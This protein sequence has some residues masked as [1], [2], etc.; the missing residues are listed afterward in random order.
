MPRRSPRAGARP[1]GQPTLREATGTL[2]TRETA[3]SP[4]GP[5]A[6]VAA[7]PLA[8][9]RGTVV[10]VGGPLALA[11]ASAIAPVAAVRRW[12]G[13][14]PA[15]RWRSLGWAATAAG[16]AT[17]WVYGLA[18]RPWLQHWGSTRAERTATYP[19]DEPGGAPWFRTTRAVTVAAPAATVWAWL[20]QIGQD[21]GGFYSYDWL[22]N[23]AGCRLRSADRIHEEWQDLRPGDPLTMFPGFSTR[24]V[25]VDPARSV[26]IENWGSYVIDP[27][28]D[29]R[30]RLVARS[31]QDRDPAGL[32]YVA[33]IELPHAVMER[34][35]LLGVKHRAEAEVRRRGVP[36][37]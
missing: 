15:G 24:I 3:E 32:G 27:I 36:A 37:W 14:L 34:K 30:C 8:L 6:A 18:I 26:V 19:G 22:E 25:E 11:L 12:P 20:V 23:L 21:K 28:D 2:D 33:A 16:V 10:V 35:M 31:H 5:E 7:G 1:A 4:S 29:G 9:V 17:P 13:R